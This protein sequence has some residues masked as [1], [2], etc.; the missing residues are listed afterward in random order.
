MKEVTPE[1][2]FLQKQL[3]EMQLSLESQMRERIEEYKSMEHFYSK[4][5]QKTKNEGKTQIEGLKQRVGMIKQAE[6]VTAPPQ[7]VLP[8]TV[9]VE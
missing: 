9:S 4:K 5:L 2:Q 1:I 3:Q 8:P 7:P 6:L